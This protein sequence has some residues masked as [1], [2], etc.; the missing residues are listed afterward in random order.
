METV[1]SDST[2][3][4]LGLRPTCSQIMSDLYP[5]SMMLHRASDEIKN[6]VY[7]LDDAFSDQKSLE[8]ILRILER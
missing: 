6:K 4:S 3:E 1:H 7:K 5:W 2:L 8:G